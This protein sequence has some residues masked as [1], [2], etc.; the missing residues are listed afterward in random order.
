MQGPPAG[1][2]GAGTQGIRLYLFLEQ[3][4][5]MTMVRPCEGLTG[6]WALQVGRWSAWAICRYAVGPCLCA[7]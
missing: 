4:H 2:G 5:N 3:A 1:T 6:S 7:L